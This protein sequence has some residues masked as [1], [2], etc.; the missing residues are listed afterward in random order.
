MKYARFAILLG[1]LV[2]TLAAVC[3]IAA[4]QAQWEV[5]VPQKNVG[6]K[7][8]VAA[9]HDMNFGVTGGAGDVGKA[10]YSSDGG[11]TW[12]TADSSGG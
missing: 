5:V 3:V 10:H 11:Q 6:D 2:L 7:L 12:T 4:P 1:L 9:F 8:R